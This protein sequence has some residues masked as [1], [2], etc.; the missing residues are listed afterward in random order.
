MVLVAGLWIP[1]F[2]GMTGMA[3]GN[4]GWGLGV[5]HFSHPLQRPLC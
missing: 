5:L 1:A 2:A 3:G 4:D